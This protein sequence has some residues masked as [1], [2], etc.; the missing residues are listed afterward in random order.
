MSQAD[1]T[2]DNIVSSHEGYVDKGLNF[3]C[4]E[5]EGRL[6]GL[7][8]QTGF[9]Q[10]QRPAKKHSVPF[11]LNYYVIEFSKSRD[12]LVLLNTSEHPS[13]YK[14]FEQDISLC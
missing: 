14:F 5:A 13:E 9:F 4:R 3:S 7:E 11:V 2:S 6:H 10:R 1:S 12:P 8:F